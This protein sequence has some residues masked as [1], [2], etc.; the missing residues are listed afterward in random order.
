MA[1]SV[2]GDTPSLHAETDSLQL[3][4]VVVGSGHSIAIAG[5]PHVAEHGHVKL[6]FRPGQCCLRA[7]APHEDAAAVFEV[8]SLA[9]LSDF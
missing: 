3:A 7:F 6:L 2:S 9:S 5:V 8:L 1:V 4:T